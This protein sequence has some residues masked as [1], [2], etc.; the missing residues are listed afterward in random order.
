MIGERLKQFRKEKGLSQKDIAAAIGMTQGY[1]SEV[2]KGLKLPGSEFLISLKK[3]FGL[4]LNWFLTGETQ[5]SIVAEE[6]TPYGDP[7]REKIN[8]HLDQM[9][10]DQRRDV[11]KYA[12]EKK[13]IS[14]L[15]A[16]RQG[17]KAG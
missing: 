10:E 5:V 2:E 6:H 7:V 4:D 1:I 15:M 8:Q 3:S 13:L 14:E 12:E 9:C 16:E 11:L 17:K